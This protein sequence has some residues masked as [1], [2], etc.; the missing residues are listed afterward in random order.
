[1][2]IGLYNKPTNDKISKY[3]GLYRQNNLIDYLDGRN[4]ILNNMIEWFFSL[5]NGDMPIEYTKDNLNK[6]LH[7]LKALRDEKWQGELIMFTDDTKLEI[8]SGFDLIGYDICADSMYYSPLGDGFLLSYIDNDTFFLK[9]SKEH[10]REYVNDLTEEGLFRSYEV[11]NNFAN[12]CNIINNQYP[13]IVESEE[14]WRPFA[15]YAQNII[16]A[17]YIGISS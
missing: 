1:M 16:S 11:A 3:R 7:L 8:P 15:I 14:N 6:S 10:Y 5:S 17:E 12:Y 13:H 9:M 4:N 2:R